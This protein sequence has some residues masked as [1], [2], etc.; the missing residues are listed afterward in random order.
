MSRPIIGLYGVSGVGKSYLLHQLTGD[1]SSLF[2]THYAFLEGSQVLQ[3]VVEGGD[4]RIM[5]QGSPSERK[6]WR[7][8]AAQKIKQDSLVGKNVVVAGHYMLWDDE[9]DAHGS[10]VAVDE[11]WETYTHIVYV[12]GDPATIK[13]QRESDSKAYTRVRSAVS[14]EHLR[15]WQDQEIEKLQKICMEK[16]IYFAVVEA[17]N[18]VEKVG[19]LL[20]YFSKAWR[21]DIMDR[22]KREMVRSGFLPAT[23]GAGPRFETR[24]LL[25]ADR[26]IAAQDTGALFWRV[27]KKK[28]GKTE[29]SPLKTIFDAAGYNEFAFRQ[30]MLFYEEYAED[31]EMICRSVAD[32]VKLYPEFVGLLKAVSSK[33]HVKTIILTCELRLVWEMVLERENI[34]NVVV[35]GTGPVSREDSLVVTPEVKSRIVDALHDNHHRVI[36]FGDSPLD[37]RM[38]QKADVAYVVVGKE[39]ERS[40][41]MESELATAIKNGTYPELQSISRHHN[42][43]E[44]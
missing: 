44:P 9:K 12:R 1:S 28:T 19:T 42:C 4:L 5:S 11:D 14:T 34:G 32:Q 29:K 21:E 2:H 40:K 39:N 41:T 35:I 10:I 30:A 15:K 33:P 20:E 43:L 23:R 24:L 16:R 26:T 6:K 36:A 17:R 25:D 31:F 7:T 18:S 3:S 8:Q 27:V 37:L 22:V 38:M 13:R